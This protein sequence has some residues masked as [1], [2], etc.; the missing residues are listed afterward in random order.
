MLDRRTFLCETASACFAAPAILGATDKAGTRLPRIGEGDFVFECLHSWGEL[1]KHLTWTNTHGVAVDRSGLVYVIHQGDARTPCDTVVV[2]DAEGAFVRSFGKELA[3]GGHG[4]AIRREGNEEFLYLSDIAQ[5]QVVKCDLQGEWIWKIRYPREAQRYQSL[6]EFSPTNV[7]FAPNG[8]FYVADG[9]GSHLIHQ[10]RE[11][12][13]WIRSWGG[14]GTQVG[15]FQTPHGLSVVPQANAEPLLVIADR[16]NSRLQTCTLDGKPQGVY[17]GAQIADDDDAPPVAVP[18]HDAEGNNVS[19]SL[20]PGL[21]A[22]ADLDFQDEL[23][24]VADLHARVHLLDSN[25]QLIAQ[26]GLDAD[27][28]QQVLNDPTIRQNPA[29]WPAGRFLHPHDACFDREGNL[30]VTE[31][32]RPGRITLLR[33]L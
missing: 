14:M 17:Q 2:F 3:G 18:L 4:I 28:T 22:P 12:G 31:W 20:L 19:L 23:I 27:W 8:D 6:A 7:C 5:R 13:N 9:Y 29:R 10:Y 16:G 1:P 24:V 15:K 30:L 21:S 26:L 33:W 25:L 11:D 32:L